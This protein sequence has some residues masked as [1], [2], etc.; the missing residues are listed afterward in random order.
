M[1]STWNNCQRLQEIITDS[2]SLVGDEINE[3]HMEKF[4]HDGWSNRIWCG[5]G[6]RR[7]HVDVVDATDTKRLWMMHVCIMP[8]LHNGG[9]IYGLD[10]VAGERKVTGFFLDYSMSN[11]P[12]APTEYYVA[13]VENTQWNKQRELP[14]WAKMIFSEHMVAAGNIQD[15]HEMNTLVDLATD[16]LDY[17]LKNIAS[18]NNTIDTETGKQTQNSYAYHQKLNPHTPRVMKN[19]GLDEKLVELFCSECLFPELT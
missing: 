8:H 4:N 14:E 13:S 10:I 2:I 17:Y 5:G 11:I 15:D 7:A 12:N 19:L 16:T 3:P 18:L 9:P 1:S 6:F